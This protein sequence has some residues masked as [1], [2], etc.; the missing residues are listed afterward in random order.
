MAGRFEVFHLEGRFR[1]RLK[2]SN[3]QII[4]TG[5]DYATRAAALRGIEAARRA[6]GAG[7]AGAGSSVPVKP[8]ELA[9]ELQV[10]QV[11]AQAWRVGYKPQP[12]A[13]PPYEHAGGQRWDCPTGE[14]RTVYAGATLLACFL[15]VLA[16]FRPDP[17]LAAELDGIILDLEDM[18]DDQRSPPPGQVPHSWLLPRRIASARLTGAY[19]AVTAGPSIA[20]LRLLFREA[21]RSLGSQDFDAAALKDAGRRELT[22]AV[23]RYVHSARRDLAGIAFRSRHGDE[24]Q[25]WAIFERPSDGEVSPHLAE[26]TSTPIAPTNPDLV[27]A[28]SLFGLSW[29]PGI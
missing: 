19:C 17:V 25:L 8:V 21:A 3:G 13:W 14:F 15:E 11:A 27:E 6:A 4:A 22:Q 7:G 23:T 10:D 18:E 28:F 1:W 26:L 16:H 9:A 29:A 24:H 20:A 12:W 5:D 2:A